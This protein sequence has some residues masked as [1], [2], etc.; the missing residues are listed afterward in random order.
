M[1]ATHVVY[2]KII[3]AVQGKY[4]NCSYKN[5][6]SISFC[7]QDAKSSLFVS[8]QSTTQLKYTHVCA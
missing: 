2:V 7:P 4:K 1:R 3:V 5:V 8:I 6:M